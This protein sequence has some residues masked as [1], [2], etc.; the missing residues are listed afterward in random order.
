MKI[1]FTIGMGPDRIIRGDFYACQNEARA[2]VV[3][4][5]GFKG[6]K[7]WGM[8]PY[9]AERLSRHMHAIT[10]NFSHNGVG[11][12]LLEF[13]ELDKFAVN[14]YSRELE[15]LDKVVS[16]VHSGRLP[17]S[18][19]A[20]AV[21]DYAH[22]PMILLGHSRGGAVSM[23]YALDNPELVHGMIGW[24]GSMNT[25]IFS[26]E[27]KH[28]MRTEGRAYTVNARTKQR[29]PLDRVILEDL[30]QNRSRFDILGR[31]HTLQVPAVLIQGSDDIERIKQNSAKF[32]ERN[33]RVKRV[34]V[35]GANH[36]FQAVHPFQGTTPQL[37]EAIRLTEQYALEFAGVRD[38]MER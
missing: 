31:A 1:A 13:T 9:A 15:D 11:E 25:D 2:I 14:T 23:I 12:D 17:L 18:G 28:K 20:S 29:M 34:I 38:M 8:F 19:D 37:E 10:F 7:D 3:I 22:L 26:E 35:E 21:G 5:H 33:P 16:L 27:D 24:N 6:F 32:V 4:C 30:E 36:T